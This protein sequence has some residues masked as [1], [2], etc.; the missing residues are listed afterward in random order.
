MD[1]MELSRDEPTRWIPEDIPN[2]GGRIEP[3]LR[4]E[5]LFPAFHREFPSRLFGEDNLDFSKKLSN[6]L[7]ITLSSI[8]DAHI[9]KPTEQNQVFMDAL[10]DNGLHHPVV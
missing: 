4:L 6:T 7:S 3:L 1:C 2:I 5:I 9:Q 10:T 8:D